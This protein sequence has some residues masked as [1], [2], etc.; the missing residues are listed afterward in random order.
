MDEPIEEVYFHWLYYKVASVDVPTPSLTYWNLIRELHSYEFVWLLPGDDNRAEDG[1]DIRKEFLRQPNIDE[2]PY[3]TNFGC[4]I[5]EMLIALSRRMEFETDIA[6]R[7]WFW[8]FLTNLGINKLNDA[9][10]ITSRRVAAVLDRFVWRTYR[11][12]GHGGIF[13]LRDPEHDQRKV[14]IWYQMCEYLVD[15]GI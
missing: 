3:W 7:T 5:L 14:E 11:R 6:S 8:T 15:Q 10:T 4:S 13:P 1:L 9:C 12:D 2:D